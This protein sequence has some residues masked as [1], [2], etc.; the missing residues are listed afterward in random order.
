MRRDTASFFHRGASS[1]ANMGVTEDKHNVTIDGRPVRV[2][3]TTGAVRATWQLLEADTVLA[4][5]QAISG[6]FDLVGTLSTGTQV[7][8]DQPI[9]LRA[10]HRPRHRPRGD[11]GGV[12]R[13]RRLSSAEG[14]RGPV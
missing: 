5:E 2:T 10:N 8:D 11:R 9:S 6:E 7:T 13:L 3:G 4:E 1:I 12:H 14:R